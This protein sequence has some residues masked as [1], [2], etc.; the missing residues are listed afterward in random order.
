MSRP[1]RLPAYLAIVAI[2][3]Q[4]L[5]PLLAQA[6]PKDVVL[7][8][9]CTVQGV[10]HYIELPIRGAP[11]EPQS[12]PRAA[13]QHDHCSFCTGGGDRIAPSCSSAL[14]AASLP[15]FA[16]PASELVLLEYQ[17][18]V[19]ARPRAPPAAR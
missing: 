18:P 3:L 4:A 9:V 13:S 19:V 8:P 10:T 12:D 15:S 6:R 5:W 11:G 17:S 16:V 7:V 14:K 1:R 2:A